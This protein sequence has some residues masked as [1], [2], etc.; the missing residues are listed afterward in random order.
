MQRELGFRARIGMWA[1]VGMWARVVGEMWDWVQMS[2]DWG[3]GEVARSGLIGMGS[4]VGVGLGE[5]G[6]SAMYGRDGMGSGMDAGDVV[7]FKKG[8]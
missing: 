1:L 8:K 2:V 6:D 4:G 5:C 7:G 3:V